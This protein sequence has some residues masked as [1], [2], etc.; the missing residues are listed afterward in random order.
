MLTSLHPRAD[1]QSLRLRSFPGAPSRKAST[2]RA[3]TVIVLPVALGLAALGLWQL[4]DTAFHVDPNIL[5]TPW[6]VVTQGWQ[7]RAA[8]WSNTVPTLE[9]TSLGFAVSLASAFMLAV[10]MQLWVPCR[11]ALYPFLIISQ[12]LPLIAIAPIV[13]I[14]LGLGLVPKL[15]VVAIVTFFPITVGLTEGFR[16]ADPGA[17]DLLRSMGATRSMIFWK[18]ELPTA[19]PYFFAGLRIAITYAVVGA[20]FAEYVGASSG[21]GIFMSE[22]FS[23]FRTDLVYACV[24]VIATVSVGLFAFTHIVERLTIPWY[25]LSRRAG[26]P[27]AVR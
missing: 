17:V 10:V 19:M 11:R 16:A 27:G 23:Q 14:W 25:R 4:L 26:G 7:W 1:D 13:D 15:V 5:P 20:V 22:Q 18:L 24:A 8:I 12:T 2:P 9:E 3:Y 6:R 21:L